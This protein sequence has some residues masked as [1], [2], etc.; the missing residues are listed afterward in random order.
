MGKKFLIKFSMW[1]QSAAVDSAPLS[2]QLLQ[3]P[4]K[5]A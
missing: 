2:T 1:A 3:G 5:N 4:F